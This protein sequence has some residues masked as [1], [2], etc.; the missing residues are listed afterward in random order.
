M[1]AR[2]E[3]PIDDD[4]PVAR[5]EH[6]GGMK[7]A[8]TQAIVGRQPVKLPQ[9]GVAN[10]VGHEIRSQSRAQLV[11]ERRQLARTFKLVH[12]RVQRTACAAHSVKAPRAA[13]HDAE[14][15]VPID[16]IDDEPGPALD[17]DLVMHARDRHA[18]AAG[19]FQG[20]RLASQTCTP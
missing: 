14:Q 15:I 4:R 13:L 6:A 1:T 11:Y 3:R 12:P 19:A 2:G 17:H 8:V 7:V 16:A 9:R 10:V 18:R 20:K 5:R